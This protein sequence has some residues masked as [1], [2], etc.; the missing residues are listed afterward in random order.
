MILS[1]K[2]NMTK[3]KKEVK[4]ITGHVMDYNSQIFYLRISKALDN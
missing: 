2:S 4:K 1:L 3:K